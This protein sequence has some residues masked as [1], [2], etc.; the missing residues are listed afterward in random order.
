[1]ITKYL[2]NYRFYH[3]TYLLIEL[4]YWHQFHFMFIT[5][6]RPIS[7][8]PRA[9]SI[10]LTIHWSRSRSRWFRSSVVSVSISVSM[11]YGLINI[12]C[13]W[14]YDS[15]DIVEDLKSDADL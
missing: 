9:M 13:I 10:H 2:C 14:Q 15:P 7:P 1:M 6:Y 11:S 12:P 4:T 8:A 5:L 3:I